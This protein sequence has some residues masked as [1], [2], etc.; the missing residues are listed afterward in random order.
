M[1]GAAIGRLGCFLNGCCFGGPCELPWAVT[2]PTGSPVHYHQVRHGQVSIHG[3]RLKAGPDHVPVIVGVEKGSPAALAGVPVGAEIVDIN[4]QPVGGTVSLDGKDVEGIDAAY[5]W[6][7]FLADSTDEIVV[8]VREPAP[9]GPSG[10]KGNGEEH[11]EAVIDGAPGQPAPEV[12]DDPKVYRWKIEPPRVP[13]AVHPTQLY[14]SMNSLLI[15]LFLLAVAPYCRR[16]GQ[17]WAALLTIYPVTRFLLE[18]IRKDEP[19]IFG[20][21]MSISQNVSLVLLAVAAVLWIYTWRWGKVRGKS[22]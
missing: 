7:L 6:M 17:V 20:T 22:L 2:F 3:L 16:D 12:K 14:S 21:Q 15:C 10:A 9:G 11:N 4:G 5:H 1:L 19:E 13:L 18:I 8:T